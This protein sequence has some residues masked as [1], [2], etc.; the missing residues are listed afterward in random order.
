MR[1][2]ITFEPDVAALVEA[3]RRQDG[4][5]VS[6]AV[7]RLVRAGARQDANGTA[8][9]QHRSADVGVTVDVTNVAEVLDLLDDI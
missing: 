3:V 5:G 4:V 8:V 6:E 2:T 1:T 7:N 9:Y